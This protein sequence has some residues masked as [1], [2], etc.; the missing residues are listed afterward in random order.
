MKLAKRRERERAER[1]EA[2]LA[3]AQ[4]VFATKGFAVATMDDVADEA[5]L[6]KGTIYLY[7]KNKDD[8]FLAMSSRVVER[9]DGLMAERLAAHP[10]GSEALAAMLTSYARFAIDNHATFRTAIIWI[11]MGHA[12]DTTTQAFTDY[13]TCVR[14]VQARLMEAVE[15]GKRDGSMRPEL[16]PT[17]TAAQIWAGMLGAILFRINAVEVTRR[18]PANVDFEA[19]IPGFVAM[20]TAGLAPVRENNRE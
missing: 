17:I 12:A 18:F 7:F 2:I 20:L 8:L 10:I 14:S 9:I 4:A 1:R 13:R 19:F 15:R 16:E 5:A 11:A 6:S 3:A